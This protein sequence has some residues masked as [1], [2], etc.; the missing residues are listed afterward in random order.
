MK[1]TPYFF[2]LKEGRAC[3]Y[4]K[5]VGFDGTLLKAEVINGAWSFI[6]NVRTGFMTY[7][8]PSGHE[9]VDGCEVMW[10][11]DRDFGWDYN[12]A[13]RWVEDYLAMNWLQRLLLDVDARAGV[14]VARLRRS[15]KAFSDAWHNREPAT[16]DDIAF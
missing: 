9:V 5:R 13:F 1:P 14:L 16:Y 6:I 15:C 11:R 4:C 7:D 10:L 2:I 3:L 8:S 12:E